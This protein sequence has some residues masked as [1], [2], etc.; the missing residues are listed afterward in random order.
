MLGREK[1]S[2]VSRTTWKPEDTARRDMMIYM[3]NLFGELEIWNRYGDYY[4]GLPADFVI[5]DEKKIES[6]MKLGEKEK[7]TFYLR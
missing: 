1:T 6:Y 3:V 5:S 7:R 4:D 2:S